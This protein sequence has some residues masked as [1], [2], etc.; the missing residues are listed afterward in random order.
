M[1][2]KKRIAL[3]PEFDGLV[4]DTEESVLGSS[5]HQDAIVD[6]YVSLQLYRQKYNLPWFVGNQTK[7]TIPRAVG[8][9]YQPSPD[10]LVHSTLGEGNWASL[11]VA[12]YGPPTLAIEVLSPTTALSNDLNERGKVASY[13]ESGIAEYLAFDLFGEFIPDQVRAWRLGPSGAYVPW[14][15]DER[16]HW[17]SSLGIAFAP[18][19]AKLR[20]YDAAGVVVPGYAMQAQQLLAAVQREADQERENAAL[21]AEVRRLRGGSDER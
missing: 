3:G 6:T 16:G 18:Q 14:A 17:A 5:A 8:P 2:V 11:S 10:I 13:A 7:L 12:R 21:R 9:S 1:V 4:D 19:G 20:V 15:P